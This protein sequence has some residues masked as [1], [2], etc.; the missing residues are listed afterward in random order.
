[1][2]RLVVLLLVA[3][4]LCVAQTPYERLATA[5]KL[6]AYVK[7]IHP[8]VTASGIDWDAAFA[9]AAPKMLAAKDDQE[10]AAATAE[11][12][13]ALGDPITRIVSKPD[14]TDDGFTGGVPERRTEDGITV[15]T[16]KPGDL[17]SAIQASNSLARSLAGSG[18]VV[19]DLRGSKVASDMMP[20][21]VPVAKESIGPALMKRVHSGYANDRF[22]G[23]GGY[24]SVWEMEDGV[25]AGSSA[26][27]IRAIF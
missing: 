2:R 22:Q 4:T 5:A 21:S 1:M 6:W 10:F 18:T 12:L 23:S 16:L 8:G 9:K 20:E 14:M 15:V 24:K 27:G 11:M 25:R 3:S 17:M 13:A 26:S 7:Y 19:F